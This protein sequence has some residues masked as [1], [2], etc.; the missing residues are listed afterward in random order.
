M[1]TKWKEA[2]TGFFSERADQVESIPT[3][4]DLCYV[5]GR[6]PRLWTNEE[7]Y[8]DLIDSLVA[9]LRLDRQSD[10]LEVGCASGFLARGLSPS[11][12]AYTGVDVSKEALAVARRL[13]LPNATFRTADGTNLPFDD[14]TFDAACCYDVFT[15][16][17]AFDI[18]A[19]IIK[20]MLRVVK[21]GGRVLVG[22]V[23]DAALRVPYEARTAEVSAELTAQ[24]GPVPQR[25]P[26]PPGLAKRLRAWVRPPVDPG[27]VCYY[28]ARHDFEA[29]ASEL[30]AALEITGT[31]ARNPY[32]A[33]RFNAIFTKRS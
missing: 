30:G 13:A 26:R 1:T 22:S 14:D 24:F 3:P 9:A 28:F 32:N 11:V 4:L 2:L 17:P 6:D 29:L 20:D 33:Y 21:P 10:V 23:P 25:P 8:R 27:V 31:H 7:I 19:A 12:R 18:G 16:F 5:S 15:N